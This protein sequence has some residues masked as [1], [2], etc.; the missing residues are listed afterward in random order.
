MKR[1]KDNAIVLSAFS[2]C[3]FGCKQK[4]HKTHACPE[5]ES[6]NVMSGGNTVGPGGR[7]LGK[8]SEKFQG[9]CNSCERPGTKLQIVGHMKKISTTFS[10]YQ[11]M[12]NDPNMRIADSTAIMV[13]TTPHEMGMHK[14]KD[15]MASNLI[16][17]GNG[18][19]EKAKKVVSI[20][21]MCCDKHCNKLGL[22]ELAKVTHLPNGKFNLFS[23]MKM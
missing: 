8:S 21:V 5:K 10:S 23:I 19:N 12:L 15:A 22:S 14:L 18:M 20:S 17:I 11:H 7:N 1:S 2:R 9:R 13:H 16:T 3:C 4:G 6:T